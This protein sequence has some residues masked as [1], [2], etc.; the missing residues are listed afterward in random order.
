MDNEGDIIVLG[1]YND[2][3]GLEMGWPSTNFYI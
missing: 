2:L 1:T 3:I